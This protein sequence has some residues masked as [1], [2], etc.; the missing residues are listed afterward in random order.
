MVGGE[1]DYLRNMFLKVY[2]PNKFFDKA[3][4]FMM[5]DAAGVP[6]KVKKAVLQDKAILEN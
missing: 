4:R 5:R 6:N 1:R 3:E 2:M